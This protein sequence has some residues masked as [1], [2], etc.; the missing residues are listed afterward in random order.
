M[1]L[2]P[3]AFSALQYEDFANQYIKA[4]EQGTTTPKT[5]AT[6]ITGLTTAS[7]FQLNSQGFPVTAGSALV[8]PFIDGPY[9]LWIIP[10]AAEADDN[11]T[12]NALQIADNII[13]FVGGKVAGQELTTAT[14][15]GNT[16]NTYIVNDIVGTAE[17]STGNGGGGTY[18]VVLTSSVTPNTFNII[19]GV[20]DNSI[21]FVLRVIEDTVDA[22][23][24]GITYDSSDSSAAILSLLQS[25]VYSIIFSDECSMDSVISLATLTNDKRIIGDGIIKWSGIAT[26]GNM[27][28]IECDGFD[29]RYDINS[30]GNNLMCAGWLIENSTAMTSPLPTC[31]IKG[32]STSFRA[33]LTTLFNT[34]IFVRG[35][36]ELVDVSGGVH[37]DTT[38]VSGLGTVATQ[39]M[40]VQDISPTLFPR[41]ILHT[42]NVYSGIDTDDTG[43]SDNDTDYFFAK[44]PDPTNF[45]IGGS[46]INAHAPVS[47]ESHSNTYIN[48]IGRSEKYQCVPNTHD[49]VVVRDGDTGSRTISGG[50][51]D[52]NLQYGV[53]TCKNQTIFLIGDTTSP[54]STSY[55]PVSYFQGTDFGERRGTVT[56][57]NIRIYNDVLASLSNTLAAYVGL[58]LN[59]TSSAKPFSLVS[60][61][62]VTMENGDVDHATI[63]SYT[64]G[65]IGS[66]IIDGISGNFNF[67]PIALQDNHVDATLSAN[68]ISNTSGSDVEFSNDVGGGSRSFLGVLSGGLGFAGIIRKYEIGA[69][70]G[71]APMLAGGALFDGNKNSGGAL[72]VQS[73]SLADDATHVFDIRGFA[74]GNHMIM[75]NV[76]FGTHLTQGIFGC[77]GPSGNIIAKNSNTANLIDH[78][79]AGANPDTDGDLNLWVDATGAVNIKN[80]LGSTRAITIMFF[81]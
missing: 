19:V 6:D 16:N 31:V 41:A 20:A 46:G 2:A 44:L 8:I 23:A 73:V 40:V 70:A 56:V 54:I 61:T 49:N 67:N 72:S 42:K 71:R 52:F 36:F 11:D 58:Q 14:M 38:R 34:N 29:F 53:G 26:A 60:I 13:T 10:T 18:D 1:A 39:T 43:A 80:R 78:S 3:I 7:K 37:K 62:N 21:S 59:V 81:G 64:T 75:V 47:V 35:S 15:T 25:D 66:I 79:V 30:D 48:P 74:K 68:N 24:W 69:T 65:A 77:E 17:F 9:D 51:I 63:S 4:F 32:K 22:A 28:T 50:S 76:N 55:I 5:M 45:P 33:T 57:D 12:T 27:I